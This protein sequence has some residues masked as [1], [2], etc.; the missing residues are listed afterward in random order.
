MKILSLL[1][2]IMFLT[3]VSFGVLE[4]YTEYTRID[5]P[6]RNM[7]YD[8]RGEASFPKRKHL[9]WGNSTIGAMDP[10]KC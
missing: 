8:W 1:F 7:S 6:T 5:C 9:I 3:I 10:S 4:A 2:L